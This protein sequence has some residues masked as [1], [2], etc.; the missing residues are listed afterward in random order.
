MTCHGELAKSKPDPQ[1]LTLFF[2]MLAAGGAL[3]GVLVVVVAPLIF[4]FYWELHVGLVACFVLTLIAYFRAPDRRGLRGG[5][6]WGWGALRSC[7]GGSRWGGWNAC[8]IAP[9]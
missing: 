4:T 1:Y 3:G 5:W 8:R 2:L 7:P 6:A 9:S